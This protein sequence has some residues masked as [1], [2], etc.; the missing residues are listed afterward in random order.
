[1]LEVTKENFEQ[2]VLKSDQIVLV[3]WWGPKCEKCLELMPDVKALAEKY[4]TQMKFCSV[5]AAGNRRLAIAHKVLGL[6]AI[7]FYRGGEKIDEISGQEISV[8]DIEA[9]IKLYAK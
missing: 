3:D 8:E 4:Q 6:P 1:M 2:E 7:L 5:N 9:K